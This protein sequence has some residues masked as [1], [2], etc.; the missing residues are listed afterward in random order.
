M[1]LPMFPL[2][3]VLLPGS[4]LP[5]HVFEPRYREMIGEVLDA[6]PPVFGIVLISSG[7]EVG[8][9]DVR[10]DV[11]TCARILRH[12]RTDD[13]RYGLLVGGTNR[14][15]VE[16]WN[17]DRAFPQAVIHDYPDTGVAGTLGPLEVL[18]V[19]LRVS[20]L[21]NEM[22]LRV[23]PLD[24]ALSDDPVLASYE[25]IER[26]PLD[27]TER[28]ELLETEGWPDRL[29][30][31]KDLLVLSEMRMLERLREEGPDDPVPSDG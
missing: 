25:L 31:L 1:I 17:T 4:L 24:D 19:L 23:P 3:T 15:R 29:D 21:A 20:A 6:D 18:P 27:G 13:G 10:H 22:G 9:G 11:G 12:Q 7:S 2:G 16:A 14:I 5:L 26:S 8:G 30:R 28:Q